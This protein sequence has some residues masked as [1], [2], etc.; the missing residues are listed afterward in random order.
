[1]SE[2]SY[3]RLSAYLRSLPD[4]IASYPECQAKASLCR[5]LIEGMPKPLP[6][7]SEVPEPVRDVFAKPPRGMWMPE[8]E[9]MALSL[10]IA[11]HYR[12]TDEGYRRWLKTANRSLFQTLMY[13]A[14]FSLISPAPL[15][16]RGASRWAAVHKGSELDGRLVG[17][18]EGE[19]QIR[20]P[21]NLFARPLLDHFTAVFE[22][23]FEHCNAR[24]C[25]VALVAADERRGCYR[26]SWS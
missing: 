8:V 10:F 22:A 12:M 26:I 13:R 19:I 9:V 15:I 17:P 3:P 24:T 11:D 20:F 7:I 2:A 23:A 21:R 25:Q 5:T 14:L 6:K 18:T 16:V 4:G 1:V